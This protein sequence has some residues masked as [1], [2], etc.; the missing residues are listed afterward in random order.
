MGKKQIMHQKQT[1]FF[2]LLEQINTKSSSQILS[3]HQNSHQIASDSKCDETEISEIINQNTSNSLNSNISTSKS[4][5]SREQSVEN[6]NNHFDI[7]C[8]CNSQ[9]FKTKWTKLSY[10]G[11]IICDICDLKMLPSNKLFFYHCHQKRKCHKDGYDVCLQC[12]ETLSDSQNIR[13]NNT[14]PNNKDKICN[15][16]YCSYR[17][18]D[19]WTDHRGNLQS[20]ERT[21]TVR[22]LIKQYRCKHCSF[23]TKWKCSL[24]NHQKLHSGEKPFK[25]KHCDYACRQKCNLKVHNLQH[26]GH[27]PHECRICH[28]RFRTS[29]NLKSH[30]KVHEL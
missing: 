7:Q 11:P 1:E 10:S 8:V 17:N 12:V 9:L 25:C 18:C 28:K 29:T 26:T 19:Y 30:L 4:Q 27:K 13:K 14:V 6:D 21:H 20:H 15:R 22:S 24:Q 5:K 3:N 2:R 23:S 16:Y